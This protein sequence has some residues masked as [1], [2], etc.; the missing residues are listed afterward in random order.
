MYSLV[1]ISI[2][3]SLLFVGLE[4]LQSIED[5]IQGLLGDLKAGSAGYDG[6][7]CAARQVGCVTQGSFWPNLTVIL[8][9]YLESALSAAYESRQT[10]PSR[11][12]N[13]N[14]RTFKMLRLLR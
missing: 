6:A 13:H 5:V 3:F 8:R 7:D 10:W 12:Y 11:M 9:S 1:G 4:A 14:V 2:C